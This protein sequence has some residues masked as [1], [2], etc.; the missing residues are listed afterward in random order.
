MIHRTIAPAAVVWALASLVP[1]PFAQGQPLTPAGSPEPND[2]KSA[3][4]VLSGANIPALDPHTMTRNEIEEVLGA[5]PLCTYHYTTAGNP[6]LAFNEAPAE[7]APAGVVKLDG[8]LIALSPMQVGEGFGLASGSVRLLVVP[9]EL[10]EAGEQEEAVLRFEVGDQL[11]V[12]YLG[13]FGCN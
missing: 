5:G 8:E 3:E 11:T 9:E 13:Y 2:A 10:P 6:I 7:G 1:L 12:G 4:E